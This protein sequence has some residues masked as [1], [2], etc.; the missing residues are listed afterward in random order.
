MLQIDT[1]FNWLETAP[2]QMPQLV[3]WEV[4]IGS[5]NGLVPTD[6]NPLPEPMLDQLCCQMTSLRHNEL[7]EHFIN[8]FHPPHGTRPL[9]ES[10]LTDHP[11]RLMTQDV[12]HSYE[13]KNIALKL[14][15]HWVKQ[16]LFINL[17]YL[18]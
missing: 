9:L 2:M 7:E 12:N 6:T 10:L 5:V 13:F 15:P 11:W 1:T 16:P 3:C 17:L 14:Q 4:E 18:H 8:Y